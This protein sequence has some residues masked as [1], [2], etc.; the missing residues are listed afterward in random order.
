M[1]SERRYLRLRIP[2]TDLEVHTKLD[3]EGVVIDVWKKGCDEPIA[4]TWKMY[5][6]FGMKMEI[7]ED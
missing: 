5:D 2:N 3:D 1:N 6:E 7:L 4:T